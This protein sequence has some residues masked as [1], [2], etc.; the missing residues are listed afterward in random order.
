MIQEAE[1]F[2]SLLRRYRQAAPMRM[3]LS[4]AAFAAGHAMTLEEPES[5]AV[6]L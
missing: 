6:A 4:E 1:S 3:A 2:Q 5:A